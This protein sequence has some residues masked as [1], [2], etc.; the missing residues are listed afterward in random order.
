M[1]DELIVQEGVV[2]FEVAEVKQ[3]DRPERYR[4][5]IEGGEMW[6]YGFSVREALRDAGATALNDEVEAA[7]GDLWDGDGQ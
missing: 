6:S 2:S 5:R 1:S 3:E 4:A 7:L